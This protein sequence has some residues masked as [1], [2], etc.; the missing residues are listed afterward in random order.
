[1]TVEATARAL[2]FGSSDDSFLISCCRTTTLVHKHFS[3][4]ISCTDRSFFMC[5]KT[6]MLV[7]GWSCVLSAVY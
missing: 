6:D 2:N 3:K 1:M 5:Q 7:K 4:N